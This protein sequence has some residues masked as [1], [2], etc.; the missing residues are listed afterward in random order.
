MGRA[1]FSIL[2]IAIVG[3]ILSVSSGITKAA[4]IQLIETSPETGPAVTVFGPIEIGDD[5]KFVREVLELELAVV[6]L[7]SEGGSPGPA[8]EIGKSYPP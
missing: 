2:I 4:T 7:H 5:Q 1:A 3:P 8:I 6:V